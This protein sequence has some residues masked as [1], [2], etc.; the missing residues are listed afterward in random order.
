MFLLRPAC[1]VALWCSSK[2]H[3]TPKEG[4]AK[5]MTDSQYFPTQPTNAWPDGS[6]RFARR[7]PSPLDLGEQVRRW[8]LV[9]FGDGFL[10]PLVETG[11]ARHAPI[12]C[13]AQ[14]L[15]DAGEIAKGM[16]GCILAA[17]TS[18]PSPLA[19]P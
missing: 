9:C 4:E 6:S 1:I 2:G 5:D 3:Q 15:Q 19:I 17:S 11:S 10:F 18:H 12:P 7:R 16:V 14:A 13:D 8:L